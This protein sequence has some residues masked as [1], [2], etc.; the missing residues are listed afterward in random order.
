MRKVREV[1]PVLRFPLGLHGNPESVV[2]LV[3]TSVF[4]F[5]LMITNIKFQHLEVRNQV[6]LRAWEGHTDD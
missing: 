6:P 5:H 1:G 2:V 3:L 4:S